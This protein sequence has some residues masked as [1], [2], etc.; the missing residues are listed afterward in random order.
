MNDS[1]IPR[2]VTLRDIA[3]S[4]GVS[5]VTVSLALRNSPKISELMRL[6]IQD[7]AR[8]A[9]YR[10]DPMLSALAHYRQLRTATPV[11]AALAWL[12]FWE[13]PEKLRSFREFDNYW[14]G[15]SAVA[16]YC[17]YRLEEFP[18]CG[19]APKRLEQILLTRNVRGILLPPR[20]ESPDWRDFNWNEFSVVRFGNSAADLPFHSVTS[21]QVGVCTLA[22]NKIREKGYSRIGFVGQVQPSWRF[23][24]GF[25]LAQSQLSGDLKIPP[26]DLPAINPSEDRKLLL[27]WLK[28][29]QPD[30]II[31][32][33]APLHEMLEAVGYRVP[34]NIGLAALSVLDGNADA[35]VNQNAEEI[36][37][38]AAE[39]L[40]SMINNNHR[41]VPAIPRQLLAAGCWVDGSTL[42]QKVSK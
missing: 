42:P 21:D 34:Q 12:N 40:I 35:G 16:N 36:G 39:M 27:A 10:P 38:A 41:G 1:S 19:M 37:R 17:G 4:V 23:S 30:A 11:H 26:L 24:A 9:G 22:F 18:C 29:H 13:K 2:R 7:V 8:E 33:I 3:K 31:T 28:K 20:S 15:A 6:K 25:L 32:V 5:H 14:K